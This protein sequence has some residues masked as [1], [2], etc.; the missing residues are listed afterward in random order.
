MIAAQG[1]LGCGR[2]GRR[3]LGFEVRVLG[4]HHGH[5]HRRAGRIDHG[6]GIPRVGR[7][8]GPCRRPHEHSASCPETP[9]GV[10]ADSLAEAPMTPGRTAAR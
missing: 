10:L 9:A 8:P 4:S 3:I 7:R 2:R 1:E 5:D 6:L